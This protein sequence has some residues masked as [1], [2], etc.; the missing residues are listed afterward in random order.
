MQK[1]K[2]PLMKLHRMGAIAPTSDMG[3]KATP[4]R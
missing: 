2:G 4:E 3:Q 1:Q